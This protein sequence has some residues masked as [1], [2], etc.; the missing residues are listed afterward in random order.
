[1]KKMETLGF[2]SLFE[3]DEHKQ[4]HFKKNRRIDYEKAAPFIAIYLLLWAK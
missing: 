3:V 4:T 1:M 2:F